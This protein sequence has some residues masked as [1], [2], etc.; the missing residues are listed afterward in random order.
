MCPFPYSIHSSSTHS[1][2]HSSNISQSG[3]GIVGGLQNIVGQNR[4]M[5]PILTEFID[6]CRPHIHQMQLSIQL[7]N[8]LRS[9][10][11]KCRDLQGHIVERPGSITVGNVHFEKQGV[12]WSWLIAVY[13]HICTQDL[14]LPLTL[15]VLILRPIL[16]TLLVSSLAFHSWQKFHIQ[17]WLCNLHF[18]PY[19]LEPLLT[20]Y[21]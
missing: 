3:S 13:Q 18:F 7:Q 2:I 4:N 10:G 1:F 16:S 15:G 5:I 9:V 17:D 11:E 20:S 8:P 21:Y 14:I 19:P 12:G 6:Q